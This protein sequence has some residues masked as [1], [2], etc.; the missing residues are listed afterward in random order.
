MQPL[1][2]MPAAVRQGVRG[3]FADID[4][5]ITSHGT[6]TPDAYAALARLRSAGKLVIPITGR[7]AGWCDHIA[8]MWP[9]DA[10]VGENG[11]FFMRYD[12]K[13]RKL[14]RRFIVAD[15][16]RQAQRARLAAIAEAILAAVPGTALA[17]DQHYRECDLA[18][19][20]CEDVPPLPRGEVD[21]IVAL[22]QAQGM[23]AKVSSIHVN[24]WFG[25]YDK[26]GMTRTLLREVF[27]VDLDREREHYVFA[28]DSPNDAPMFAYFPNAVG[29]AN[30][31]PF[32]DRIATPPRWITTREAGAGFVELADFLLG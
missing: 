21:R 24:G 22:M 11:A 26:L 5:T 27:A 8:R 14:E 30:V 2:T 6:L 17:S 10:V 25:S 32:L 29:V 7:P 20:F 12:A 9:V 16:E 23:T 18:I 4:D 28:G 13:R 15:A 31:L 19:D 3:V 1:A